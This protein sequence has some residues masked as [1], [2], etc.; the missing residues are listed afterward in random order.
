MIPPGSW[1]LAQFWLQP[2]PRGGDQCPTWVFIFYV[3]LFSKLWLMHI[4]VPSVNSCLF[5]LHWNTKLNQLMFFTFW[6]AV[7]NFQWHSSSF[8]FHQAS[9][10]IL[11]WEL[12]MKFYIEHLIKSYIEYFSWNLT[13]SIW[14]NL[15]DVIH[16]SFDEILHRASEEEKRK[17]SL[18]AVAVAWVELCSIER[19]LLMQLI[20]SK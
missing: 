3:F 4:D 20:V 11:H 12:L 17:L 18:P 16:W 7:Q 13:L 10:E 9:D 14:W 5:Q 6:K 1:L 15:K 2:P 8:W 19:K